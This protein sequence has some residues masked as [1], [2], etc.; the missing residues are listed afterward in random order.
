MLLI[1]DGNSVIRAHV[2][3]KIVFLKVVL[4][5]IPIHLERMAVSTLLVLFSIY[6]SEKHEIQFHHLYLHRKYL[7]FATH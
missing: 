6:I 5:Y 7:S 3:G 1:I 4:F 2:Y